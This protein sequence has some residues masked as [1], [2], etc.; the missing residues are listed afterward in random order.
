MHESLTSAKS[1]STTPLL[2]QMFDVV[3]KSYLEGNDDGMIKTYN[4]ECFWNM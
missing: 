4:G 1:S 2:N 3:N